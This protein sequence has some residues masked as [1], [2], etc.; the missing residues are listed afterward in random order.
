MFSDHNGIKLKINNKQIGG[1]GTS[2]ISILNNTG[3]RG[4]LNQI[5]KL[6]KLKKIKTQPIKICDMQLKQCSEKIY[7]IKCLY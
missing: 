2:N 3:L 1:G 4:T 6:F 7:T 5:E